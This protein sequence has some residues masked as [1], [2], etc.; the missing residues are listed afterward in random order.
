[1][2]VVSFAPR[3]IAV[4]PP[5]GTVRMIAASRL[6]LGARPLD[7]I[8]ASCPPLR[9]LSFVIV[10]PLLSCNS[11]TGSINRPGTGTP[12]TCIDGP[13]ARAIK[14]LKPEPFTVKPAMPTLSPVCTMTRPE[15]LSDSTSAGVP[16]GVV[17]GV[18]LAV[19][20]AVGVGVAVAVAVGVGLGVGL[21][22]GVGV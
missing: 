16:V 9:Q 17:V 13:M 5:A 7:W 22:V 14:R 4:K 10:A 15:M 2:P 18:G 20:V 11:R 8:S 21:G 3:M 6:S 12:L 1:M 19:G